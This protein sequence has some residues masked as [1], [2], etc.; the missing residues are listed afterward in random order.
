MN[1]NINVYEPRVNTKSSCR[2]NKNL[3]TNIS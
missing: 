3:E 2:E 1:L